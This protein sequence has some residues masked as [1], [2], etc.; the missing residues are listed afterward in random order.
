MGLGKRIYAIRESRGRSQSWLAEETKLSQSYISAL[1]SGSR[2]NP[3][4]KTLEK[5]AAALV[6]PVEVLTDEGAAIPQEV[7]N[8]PEDLLPWAVKE[9]NVDYMIFVK[10]MKEDG[11]T[12]EELAKL[13]AFY[14]DM[15]KKL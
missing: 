4:R 12:P 13:A 6:V 10:Q 3:T 5:I 15:K 2:I 7:F 1:E 11:L 14:K 9:E 8:L